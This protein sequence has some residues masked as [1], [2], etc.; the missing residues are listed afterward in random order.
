MRFLMF[1]GPVF[2]SIQ[3]VNKILDIYKVFFPMFPQNMSI[4][5]VYQPHEN[6]R[7]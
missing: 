1:I 4:I 2:K 3:G 7:N 5:R 6:H